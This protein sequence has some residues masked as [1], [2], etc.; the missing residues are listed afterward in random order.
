MDFVDQIDVVTMDSVQY[1]EASFQKLDFHKHLEY[2]V[3]FS[4]AALNSQLKPW[5]TG[6]CFFLFHPKL[7]DSFKF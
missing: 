7:R 1:R 3:N 4:L 6:D 2:I 5:W